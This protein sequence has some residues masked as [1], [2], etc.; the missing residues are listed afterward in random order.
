MLIVLSY[1]L[2]EVPGRRGIFS[3]APT[4]LS[5]KPKP[6]TLNEIS[7]TPGFNQV[8]SQSIDPRTQVWR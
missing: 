2:S 4:E 5:G 8:F 3:V 1:I 6:L 7:L